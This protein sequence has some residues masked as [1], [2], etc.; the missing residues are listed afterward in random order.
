MVRMSC[1]SMPLR[2]LRMGNLR[3]SDLN[4]PLIRA[5]YEIRQ[6]VAV[7][8]DEERFACLEQ[9]RRQLTSIGE[10]AS[11]VLSEALRDIQIRLEPPHQLSQPQRSRI[12]VEL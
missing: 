12:G 10:R 2:V 8:G 4:E 1:S 6:R 3:R 9:G 5:R 11:G 7:H